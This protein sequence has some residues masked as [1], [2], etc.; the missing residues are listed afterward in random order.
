MKFSK[1]IHNTTF[2][3][4]KM[5]RFL[6]NHLFEW[7]LHILIN[8]L[9]EKP[10]HSQAI[11]LTN[12]HK[13]DFWIFGSSHPKTWK[14]V[15]SRSSKICTKVSYTYNLIWELKIKKKRIKFLPIKIALLL[16]P[17]FWKDK[18]IKLHGLFICS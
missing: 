5:V 8:L 3:S 12:A 16:K 2:D 10:L 7:C 6:Y 1:I 13:F 15:K 14:S 9:T 11:K 18:D 17:I 4:L